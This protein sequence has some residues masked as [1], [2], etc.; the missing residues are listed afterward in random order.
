MVCNSYA[1]ARVWG[2]LVRLSGHVG[3]PIR[4]GIEAF[5]AW[6]RDLWLCTSWCIVDSICLFCMCWFDQTFTR[7]WHWHWAQPAVWGSLWA[8]VVGMWKSLLLQ[9]Q[10]WRNLLVWFG[11]FT[12]LFF[13]VKVTCPEK[14]LRGH[15]YHHHH[16]WG[17]DTLGF[18]WYDMVYIHQGW[19]KHLSIHV[20]QDILCY[21]LVTCLQLLLSSLDLMQMAGVYMELLFETHMVFSDGCNQTTMVIS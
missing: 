15:H 12:F 17:K 5:N 11:V 21:M 20:L 14:N 6:F 16:H 1:V 9:L 19:M 7:D 13:W 10:L 8:R 2:H 3:P 4:V 18:Q